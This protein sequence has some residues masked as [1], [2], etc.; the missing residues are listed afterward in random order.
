M[1][2]DTEAK[3]VELLQAILDESQKANAA[4]GELMTQPECAEL[5]R[6]DKRTLRRWTLEG[7]VPTPVTIGRVPRW[8]RTELLK[9]IAAK[10]S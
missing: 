2:P 9:W 6:I 3:V 4:R 5:L 1:T 10:T 7:I 8:R